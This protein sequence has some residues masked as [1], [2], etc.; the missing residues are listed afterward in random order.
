[1]DYI[2]QIWYQGIDQV[3]EKYTGYRQTLRDLHPGTT[4]MV[5]DN[6]RVLQ[7][8]REEYPEYLAWY[9]KL[10]LMIQQIDVAKYFILNVYGGV[11]VDMDIRAL[12]PLYELYNLEK[13]V[14]GEIGISSLE[15][16]ITNITFDYAPINNGIIFS[17]PRHPFWPR[18]LQDLDRIIKKYDIISGIFPD[19]Y[20]L[21]TTGPIH[22]T[23]ALYT[24]TPRNTI[25]VLPPKY[26]EPQ[27]LYDG[28]D[29]MYAD[30]YIIHDHDMSWASSIVR[31]VRFVWRFVCRWWIRF[32]VTGI[33]AGFLVWRT[34]QRH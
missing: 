1:M 27:V 16:L 10:P 13:I 32:F 24:L 21:A 18:Y 12:K 29:E 20:V 15:Q 14:I 9:Q 5:W 17:P 28:N 6:D 2:H 34:L 31:P 4:I 3:P 8:L 7:L 23:R 22:F 26:L 30:S 25:I 11:Y 19:F 33:L